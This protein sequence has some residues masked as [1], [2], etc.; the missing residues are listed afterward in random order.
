MAR[1][2]IAVDEALHALWTAEAKRQGVPLH[3]YVSVAV[4]RLRTGTDAHLA[5][6][7]GSFRLQ[8]YQEDVARAALGPRVKP[9]DCTNR[10]RS[11]TYCRICGTTHRGS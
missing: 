3:T 6:R 2:T 4:E 5:V 1:K 8:A 7:G 9:A 10:L 11:G